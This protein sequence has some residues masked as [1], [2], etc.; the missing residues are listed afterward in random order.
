MLLGELL[1]DDPGRPDVVVTGFVDEATRNGALAGALALVHP[2][3][4]E[5]FA[6]VLTEAFAQRRP[7]LVQRRCAVLDGHARA[8]RRRHSRTRGF[9]EFEAAVELLR[10]SPELADALGAAGRRYVE[11]EYDWDVVMTRYERTLERV[12][13]AF[14]RAVPVDS[15]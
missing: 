11:Q 5:S 1:V 6:M 3:Y 15:D 7:A 9:A 4:F 14:E 13:R 12:A 8:Q 2:S 10:T